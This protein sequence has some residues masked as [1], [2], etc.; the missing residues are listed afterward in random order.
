MGRSAA[1]R[2]GLMARRAPFTLIRLGALLIK[3]AGLWALLQACNLA[4][5]PE[6]ASLPEEVR[7]RPHIIL[8]RDKD[9]KVLYFSRLGMLGDF[10]AWFGLDAP[11]N[12]VSDWLNGRKSAG[13]IAEEMVK[14][15]VNTLWQTTGQ[16]Y[17]LPAEVAAGRKTYPDLFKPTIVRDRGLEL[18]RTFG[19]EAEYRALLGLPSRPYAESWRDVLLYRVDPREA[20]YFD[21]LDEKRR[22]LKKI[23]KWGEYG[24]LISPRSNALYNLR[25][26]VRYQDKDAFERYLAE[27]ENLGG[28]VR[29]LATSIRNLSRVTGSASRRQGPSVTSGWMTKADGSFKWR[30]ST[31]TTRWP[32]LPACSRRSSRSWPR[33]K[34]SEYRV[35]A[36]D[37]PNNLSVL[38]P[39]SGPTIL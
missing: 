13:E 1:R 24:G 3:L 4:R 36:P 2:L 23:G 38:R 9:G 15:P 10:L 33:R 12:L 26:A 32:T 7:A 6:E 39:F 37:E 18:A 16:Q 31:T 30:W 20:A 14:G 11:A 29:G 5:F 25:Q 34:G 17:K 27:Y 28:T 22:F 8:G 21:I 35:E 19:L